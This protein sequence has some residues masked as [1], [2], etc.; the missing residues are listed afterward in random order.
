MKKAGKFLTLALTLL[1]SFS[2]LQTVAH[3]ATVSTKQP[4]IGDVVQVGKYKGVLISEK[5]LPK[6]I[7]AKKVTSMKDAENVIDNVN[8]S[9]AKLSNTA[10]TA[11]TNAATTN[12]FATLS[13]S[14]SGSQDKVNGG[15]V[16]GCSFHVVVHYTYNG[17][18][19]SSC[20]S[21]S[22][23][24]S[25]LTSF[26]S[27]SQYDSSYAIQYHGRQLL[28]TVKGTL[29]NYLITPIGLVSVG[30]SSET[31]NTYFYCS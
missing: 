3:A 19:F 17:N 13:Y 21:V 27:W 5:D 2:G 12:A 14:S 8:S 18:V 16:P 23:Y 10:T 22:S 7:V 6:N 30:S 4:K 31:V 15:P 24:L 20:S 26:V 9:F 29:T 11:T 28:T 1:M 25:G